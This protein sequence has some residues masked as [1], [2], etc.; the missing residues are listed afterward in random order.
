MSAIGE[1]PTDLVGFDEVKDRSVAKDLADIMAMFPDVLS[2]QEEIARKRLLNRLQEAGAHS[3]N[4]Y[5]YRSRVAET[6]YLI[7]GEGDWRLCIKEVS[8]SE[9]G[10]EE[11][12]RFR[13]WKDFRKVLAGALPISTGGI[14][15]YLKLVRIYVEGMGFPLGKFAETGGILTV[16]HIETMIV[17]HDGRSPLLLKDS[18]R[19]KTAKFEEDLNREYPDLSFDMQ[20][21]RYYEDY[22]AHDYRDPSAL[23]KDPEELGRMADQRLG[24]P[25]F[26]S[27]RIWDGSS[28]IGYNVH[29]EY[30]DTEFEGQTIVGS[31]DVFELRFAGEVAPGVVR[32]WVERKLGISPE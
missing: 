31:S 32:E 28:V 6:L 27:D 15:R 26:W 11:V 12:V 29:I 9:S 20:L 23:N 13:F 17:G 30:P 3:V 25:R 19:P 4:S 1:G 24:R 14:G 5:F 18:M 8:T 16:G 2:S 10:R 21:A 22:V 7:Q